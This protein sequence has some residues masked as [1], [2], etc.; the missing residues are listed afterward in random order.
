[1]LPEYPL[2]NFKK[3]S[4]DGMNGKITHPSDEAVRHRSIDFIRKK[5]GRLEDLPKHVIP[6]V[7]VTTYRCI[8]VTMKV[9]AEGGPRGLMKNTL[10][11][12]RQL[13]PK[14]SEAN[15]KIEFLEKNDF[16]ATVASI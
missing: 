11:G 16:P 4:T 1:M 3:A 13:M 6:V 9:E 15:K 7:W 5:W 10:I 12:D 8:E 14:F 2:E